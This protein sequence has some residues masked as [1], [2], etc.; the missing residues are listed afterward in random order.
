MHQPAENTA[1]CLD[2]PTLDHTGAPS[3][4]KRILALVEQ[5]LTERRDRKV[6][7]EVRD[8]PG[9]YQK[10]IGELCTS[11]RQSLP[12]TLREQVTEQ[13]LDRYLAEQGRVDLAEKWRAYTKKIEDLTPQDL[14]GLVEAD[15]QRDEEKRERAEFV[16]EAKASLERLF[17][18]EPAGMMEA[19]EK[20]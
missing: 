5:D 16:R 3:L 11:E 4:W 7:V 18:L 6:F 9:S 19:S 12:P 10:E 8:G 13:L 14:P 1:Y 2:D 17:V 15:R 20:A